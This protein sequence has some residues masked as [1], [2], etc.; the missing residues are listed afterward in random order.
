MTEN[1][2]K[3]KLGRTQKDGTD[4]RMS[5]DRSKI[6]ATLARIGTASLD[7]RAVASQL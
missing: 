2:P 5:S 6:I 4:L 1:E 3:V 7:V